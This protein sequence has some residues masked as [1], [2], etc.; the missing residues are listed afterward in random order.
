MS[1]K[2]SFLGIFWYHK[3]EVL[4][5]RIIA[6]TK[7][8]VEI[9]KGIYLHF[10]N[11]K[12][13][14]KTN[15]IVVALK[16]GL[17]RETIT[18]DALI[19]LVLRR[20]TIDYPTMKDISIKLEELYG[21]S[22]DA[23]SDKIGNNVI[24]QFMMDTISNEYSFDNSDILKESIDLLFEIILNPILEDGHFKNEYVGQEKET[25]KE[26]INSKINDKAT[27]SSDRAIEEMYKDSPYGLYK[28][29][30]VEDLDEINAK[31]LYDYY[32]G[33]IKTAE[34]NIYVSGNID[35]AQIE[36]IITSKFEAVKR[37]FVLITPED[38]S[39][40]KEEAIITE[41]QSVT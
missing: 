29:G 12:D 17:N 24:L 31:D 40:S 20:G 41:E 14:F 21:A 33:I 22:L 36:D 32:I 5:G 35:E 23:N 9:Q 15:D 16:L 10:L 30:Y 38:D 27:Y 39:P 34:I 2:V 26:L 37:D 28:Y 7:K 19:P 11:T 4:K 8:D 1:K 3:Y 13:Q 6:M 18:K 25:L